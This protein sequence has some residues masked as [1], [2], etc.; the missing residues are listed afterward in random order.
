MEEHYPIIICSS[1]CFWSISSSALYATLQK[2]F[3]H[4]SLFISFTPTP[5]VKLILGLQIGGRLLIANHLD[6]SLWLA[7]Q[8]QGAAV[9]SYQVLGFIVP[10]TSLSKL[11]QNAGPKPACFG[12]FFIQFNLSGHTQST[13]G[14]A[15]SHQF[16][17]YLWK[18]PYNTFCRHGK[19]HVYG[20]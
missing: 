16:H 1:S 10:F 8:K 7:N 4:P 2:N 20:I 3:S 6:Q 13:A 15:L 9:R 17:L 5:P 14:D 18:L 19:M 12:L 11:C